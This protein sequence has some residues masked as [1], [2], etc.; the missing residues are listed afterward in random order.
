MIKSWSKLLCKKNKEEIFFIFISITS[1][2]L[3]NFCNAEALNGLASEIFIHMY[4]EKYKQQAF[5][6]MYNRKN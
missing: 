4:I 5:T 2:H 3:N 1:I 6:A